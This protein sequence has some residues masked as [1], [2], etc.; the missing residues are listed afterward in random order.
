[1]SNSILS[2]HTVLHDNLCCREHLKTDDLTVHFSRTSPSLDVLLEAGAVIADTYMTSLSSERAAFAEEPL[3]I[4]P[5]GSKWTASSP[6]E[7]LSPLAQEGDTVLANT[8]LRM[9]DSMLH[10]EF[11]S[12]VADGDIGR[13]LNI[14]SVSEYN[15]L[16]IIMPKYST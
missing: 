12:A 8:I 13:V 3:E 14:I 7:L 1:M 9:R 16:I 4:F 15:I 10:Y 11:Q 5:E 2:S 6:S